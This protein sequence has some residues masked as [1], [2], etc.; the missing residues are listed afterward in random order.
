MKVRK[1]INY[2]EKIKWTL[3][4]FIL[5]VCELQLFKAIIV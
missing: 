2:E 4:R 1:Q 3:F 5:V